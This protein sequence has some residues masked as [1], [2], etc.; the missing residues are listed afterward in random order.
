MN[1]KKVFPLK[2]YYNKLYH[3]ND[4]CDILNELYRINAGGCCYVSYIIAKY[5]ES[6]NIPYV[7]CVYNDDCFTYDSETIY[8]NIKT[9]SRKGVFD[10]YTYSCFHIWIKIGKFDINSDNLEPER[11]LNIT[12]KDL[13]WLYNKADWNETYNPNNNKLIKNMIYGVLNGIFN[14]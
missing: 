1:S 2:K 8:N 5:L 9:R 7:V 11:V 13:K 12:S 4:L 10:L 3:L 6:K 14:P